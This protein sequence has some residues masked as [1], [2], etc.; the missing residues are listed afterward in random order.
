M[1]FVIE[2]NRPFQEKE[3]PPA[4]KKSKKDKEFKADAE[5]STDDETTIAEQEAYEKAKTKEAAGSDDEDNGPSAG[6]AKEVSQLA[7]EAEIPIEELLARYGLDPEQL[8]KPVAID[9]ESAGTSETASATDS[10]S[11]ESSGDSEQDSSDDESPSSVKSEDDESSE[12]EEKTKG[13]ESDADV[14]DVEAKEPGLED[15]LSEDEKENLLRKK[16]DS[17]SEVS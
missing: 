3:K 8:K 11:S 15:L 9:G 13:M 5:D 1:S 14:K 6:E 12:N 17:M 16:N 7:S 4:S 10:G 2:L